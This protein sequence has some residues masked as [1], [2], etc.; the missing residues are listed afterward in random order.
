MDARG[1]DVEFEILK[2]GPKGYTATRRQAGW[3]KSAAFG[4]TFRL[5]RG[6]DPQGNP[7]FTLEAK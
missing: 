3:V 7:E 1:K 6:T 5:T 2:R 4:K